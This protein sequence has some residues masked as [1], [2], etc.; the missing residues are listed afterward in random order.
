MLTITTE[1]KGLEANHQKSVNTSEVSMGMYPPYARANWDEIMV[2]MVQS[3]VP[4][5]YFELRNTRATFI[6][7][8]DPGS[9]SE[10]GN[11]TQN[12]MLR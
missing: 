10:S 2:T 9:P 11:G 5:E 3:V 6:Y 7:P 4:T 12:T 8:R 1:T